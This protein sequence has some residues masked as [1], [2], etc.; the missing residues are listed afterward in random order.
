[1]WGSSWRQRLRL[2]PLFVAM[3]IA[4]RLAGAPWLRPPSPP[5]PAGAGV[6]IVIPDRDAPAMLAEALASVSAALR[7]IDEP[8][9]VIVVAN[10]ASAAAYAEVRARY[11]DV[12]FVHSEA[13]L[14]FAGAIEQGLARVRHDWTYLMNNDM[15]LA[16]DALAVLLPRRGP[17]VFAIGSQIFQQS[18]DG[19]RE[20]TGFTDWYVGQA[21]IELFHAPVR[22]D[23][24]AY[25]HL[26]A[27]GGAALFRTALLRRYL[28]ASRCYDPV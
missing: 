17:D 27:S 13:P 19:R 14:G 11:P 3:A 21:G 28:T 16:P 12:T 20:E 15:T 22:R 8:G 4:D 9:E 25:P 2:A 24:G 26:C 7:E 10:G 6:S 5:G 1:M 18:A 23:T